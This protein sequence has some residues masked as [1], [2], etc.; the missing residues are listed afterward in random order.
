MARIFSRFISL[1][2]LTAL[3]VSCLPSTGNTG[4][5]GIQLPAMEVPLRKFSTPQVAT[6]KSAYCY[7]TA[8]PNGLR[9]AIGIPGSHCDGNNHPFTLSFVDRP[10]CAR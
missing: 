5:G 4:P 2:L 1:L 9:N 7:P 3:L 10:V 6:E 8:P